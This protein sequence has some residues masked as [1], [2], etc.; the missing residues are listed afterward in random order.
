MRIRLLDSARR[1][2]NEGYA[3]YEAQESGFD[4]GPTSHRDESRATSDDDCFAPVLA[5]K[6]VQSTSFL[7]GTDDFLMQ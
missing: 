1:D 5:T 7:P 2:L 6:H 4:G 3:F